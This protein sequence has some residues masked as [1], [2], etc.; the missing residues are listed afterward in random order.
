MR[1]NARILESKMNYYEMERTARK[2]LIEERLASAEEVAVMTCLEVCKKLL[3]TYKVVACESDEIVIVKKED[4]TKYN[5][6]VKIL[7]R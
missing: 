1:M 2:I 4:M 3:Q 7:S 5:N 6:I